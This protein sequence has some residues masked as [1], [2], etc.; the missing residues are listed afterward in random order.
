MARVFQLVHDSGRHSSGTPRSLLFW[1]LARRGS[2]PALCEA[3]GKI[4]QEDQ[5]A[6]AE[7][8]TEVAS[9]MA[10]VRRGAAGAPA[11]LRSCRAPAAHKPRQP[12]PDHHS[13]PAPPALP[14]PQLAREPG[15]PRTITECLEVL[16]GRLAGSEEGGPFD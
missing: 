2:Q 3:L 15:V 12:R 13:P 10:D 8:H 7:L 1:I 6:E 4:T 9:G 14:D 11:R 16:V 5:E